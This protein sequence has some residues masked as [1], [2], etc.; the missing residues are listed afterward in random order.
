MNNIILPGYRDGAQAVD[1]AF[2]VDFRL[3][4]NWFD[5]ERG[6]EIAEDMILGGAKVI[7]CIAGGANE[8]VLKAASERGAKVIWFDINGY[9]LGP[10]TVVGSAILHQERAAYEQTM[11]YLAGNLPFGS[12]EVVGVADG[13]VDFIEDDPHYLAAVSPEIRK[14]QGSLIERI[15]SRALDLGE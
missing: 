13:Y 14:A 6:A 5:A 10:G 9:A 15:R 2:T 3:V 11:R 8:G 7:L 4:G 1:P 12:A